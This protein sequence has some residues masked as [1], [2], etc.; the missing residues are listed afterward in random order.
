MLSRGIESIQHAA[1]LIPADDQDDQ[2]DSRSAGL[3]DRGLRFGQGMFPCQIEGWELLGTVFD[4]KAPFRM[5]YQCV[6][7]LPQPLH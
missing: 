7:A 6:I 3:I 2:F 5:F 4:G 1:S